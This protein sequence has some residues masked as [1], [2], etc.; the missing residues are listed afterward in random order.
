MQVAR[1]TARIEQISTHLRVNKKDYSSKRGLEAVLSQRKRLLRYLYRT[2][3][4]AYDKVIGELGIRSVIAGD[5]AKAAQRAA[6]AAAA[7]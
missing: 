5:S 2:D 6:A 4:P 7:Q 3:R 1:L